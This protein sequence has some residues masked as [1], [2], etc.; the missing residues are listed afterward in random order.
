V[1]RFQRAVSGTGARLTAI[2]TGLHAVWDGTFVAKEPLIAE[3]DYYKNLSASLAVDEAYIERLERDLVELEQFLFFTKGHA[4]QNVVIARIVARSPEG[5][6]ELWAD[7]GSEDGV[8]AQ[9]AVAVEDGHLIGTV[10]DVEAHRCKIRLLGSFDS[11]VPSTILGREKTLGMIEGQH[12]YVLTMNYIPQD[13]TVAQG[14]VIVTSGLDGLFPYG[15]VIGTVSSVLKNPSDPFQTAQVQPFFD[16][17]EY[18]NVMILQA[19]DTQYA[20]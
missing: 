5:G 4:N 13:A 2:G 19:G 10:S 16:A 8:T 20:Q 6:F 14:D 9:M 3:R 7:R 11:H 17:N 1:P 18:L 12:G 15:L